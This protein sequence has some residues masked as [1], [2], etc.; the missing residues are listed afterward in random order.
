LQWHGTQA[1]FT[2]SKEANAFLRC[3]YRSGWSVAGLG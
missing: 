1:K 2:N 3:K